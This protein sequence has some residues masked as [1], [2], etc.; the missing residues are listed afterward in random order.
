MALS[1]PGGLH[2]LESLSLYTTL[3]RSMAENMRT[4]YIIMLALRKN[5]RAWHMPCIQAFI[6]MHPQLR[7]LWNKLSF[8]KGIPE[9]HVLI[10]LL[11]TA[12]KLKELNTTVLTL[13]QNTTPVD[14][15][16]ETL[17]QEVA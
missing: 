1:H 12:V 11:N 8:G 9:R 15:H 17:F 3:L 4:Q 10:Q 6:K 5:D 14:K 7:L 2:H 16:Q 13:I